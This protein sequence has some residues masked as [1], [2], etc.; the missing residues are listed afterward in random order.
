MRYI[1]V[2]AINNNVVLAKDSLKG[3]EAVLMSKGIGFGKKTGDIVDDDGSK[4]QVFKLWADTKDVR[5]IKYDEKVLKSTVEQICILADKKMNISRE[6]IYKSLLDHIAF[7]IDRIMFNIPMENPFQIETYVLYSREY[8]VAKEAVEILENNL[9]VKFGEAEV[10]FIALHLNSAVRNRPVSTSLN[11]IKL[12]NEITNLIYAEFGENPENEFA[13][14]VFLMSIAEHIKISKSKISI[15]M[16]WKKHV[17][18]DA[19][20]SYILA[21]KISELV[22]KELKIEL[23][24]DSIGFITNDIEKLKQIYR[25]KEE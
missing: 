6:D 18:K 11:H 25:M 4:Q 10:G 17:F 20:T 2:K 7:S 3:E 16:P 1:V 9:N 12:Y 13:I 22:N 21:L 24:S 8:E 15:S 19:K 23:S 5:E 14:K